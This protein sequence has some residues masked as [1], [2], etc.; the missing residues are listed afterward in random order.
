MADAIAHKYRADRRRR[1]PRA[2][3]KVTNR[4][5]DKAG[6]RQRGS[7][8]IAFTGEAIAVGRAAA[9]GQVIAVTLLNRMLARPQS[10]RAA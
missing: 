3:D 7:L 8:M 4:R 1:I 10:M 2:R 5:D 6:L 9:Q